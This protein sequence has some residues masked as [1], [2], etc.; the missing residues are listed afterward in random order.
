MLMEFERVAASMITLRCST[1][2]CLARVS[3]E[4]VADRSKGPRLF[5]ARAE[6]CSR[7][8]VSC[9][10]RPLVLLGSAAPSVW[11][12]PP[13][14]P[15]RS[16]G[17]GSSDEQRSVEERLRQ[18]PGVRMNLHRRVLSGLAEQRAKDARC[19]S[20]ELKRRGGRCVP[21]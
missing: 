3:A 8:P 19:A 7:S 18:M 11:P 20:K 21:G 6:S 14:E 5:A 16:G 4:A 2:A 12:Q 10:R 13:P 17:K 1:P 9:R 15:E